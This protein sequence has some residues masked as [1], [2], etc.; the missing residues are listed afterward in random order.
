M[1]YDLLFNTIVALEERAIACESDV[2]AE[3]LIG[4][5]NAIEDGFDVDTVLTYVAARSWQ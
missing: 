4:I 5:V 3:C 1:E 2:E